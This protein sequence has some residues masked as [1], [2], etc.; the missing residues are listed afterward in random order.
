MFITLSKK[1]L[2]FGI[3]RFR[4]VRELIIIFISN[5]SNIHL[6]LLP[7]VPDS[8]EELENNFVNENTMTVN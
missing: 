6:N 4:I 1:P 3:D 7:N 2:N 5:I 8:D